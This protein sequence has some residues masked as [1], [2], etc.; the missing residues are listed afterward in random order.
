MQST[1]VSGAS[2]NQG[3]L[4]IANMQIRK[5]GSLSTS[6]SGSNTSGSE[7]GASAAENVVPSTVPASLVPSLPDSRTPS[8]NL[9]FHQD[10]SSIGTTSVSR[11][12]SGVFKR[13]KDASALSLD[14]QSQLSGASK[15]SRKLI[16]VNSMNHISQ[17]F[18]YDKH[19]DFMTKESQSGAIESGDGST[20]PVSIRGSHISIILMVPLAPKHVYLAQCRAENLPAQSYHKIQSDTAATVANLNPRVFQELASCIT[21]PFHDMFL[22]ALQLWSL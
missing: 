14:K 18:F 4:F 1:P 9:E 10:T 6:G 15:T 3:L 12:G 5:R 21:S 11:S 8:I 7:C 20:K 22:L 19:G 13:V 2:I 17:N 16:A